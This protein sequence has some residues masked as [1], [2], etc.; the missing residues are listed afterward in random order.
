MRTW[1]ESEG[2]DVR[3]SLPSS[4]MEMRWPMAGVGYRTMASMSISDS[5]GLA[6]T[7]SQLG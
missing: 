2:L 1:M 7:D 3:M 4:T 5:V 6:E